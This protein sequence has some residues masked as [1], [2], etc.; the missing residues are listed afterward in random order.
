MLLAANVIRLSRDDVVAST[1]VSSV[2]GGVFV[3]MKSRGTR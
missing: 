3:Q 2:G 1:R